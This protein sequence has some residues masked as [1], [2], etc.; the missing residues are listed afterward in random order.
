MLRKINAAV[1]DA[2]GLPDFAVFFLE[3]SLDTVAINGVLL[4]EDQQRVEAQ[5]EA[6][7]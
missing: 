6:Y 1:A 3:H 7:S 5:A 2:Y 4:G